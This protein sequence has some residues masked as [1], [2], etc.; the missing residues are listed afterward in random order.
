MKNNLFDQIKNSG[1]RDNYF[2][3][4]LTKNM[5][6]KSSKV[7][8]ESS[9]TEYEKIDTVMRSNL[10]MKPTVQTMLSSPSLYDNST[11]SSRATG[12]TPISCVIIYL[13]RIFLISQRGSLL[14]HT[15]QTIWHNRQQRRRGYTKEQK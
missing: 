8:I 2:V 12:L 15:L 11:Y 4:M 10:Q 1:S 14:T 13:L 5:M 3:N 7:Y 6:P 9:S